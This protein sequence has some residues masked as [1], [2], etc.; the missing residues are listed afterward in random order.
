VPEKT[1][2]DSLALHRIEQC[3]TNQFELNILD[4][5]I[6]KGEGFIHRRFP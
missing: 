1:G 6:P 2:D 4:G 5:G 3:P